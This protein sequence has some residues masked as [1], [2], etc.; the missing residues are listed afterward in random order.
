MCQPFLLYL[1]TLIF[2]VNVN[3]KSEKE[4]NIIFNEIF[5]LNNKFRESVF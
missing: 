3:A 2:S 5:K 4:N 1:Q